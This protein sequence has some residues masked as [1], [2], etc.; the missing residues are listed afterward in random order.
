MMYEREETRP[1]SVEERM[2]DAMKNEWKIG[3]LR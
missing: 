3:Q 1:P 2:K